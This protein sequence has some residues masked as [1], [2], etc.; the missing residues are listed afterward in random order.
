MVGND[1]LLRALLEGNWDAL[2]G[3]FFTIKREEV[4]V[5]PSNIPPDWQPFAG[6]DYGETNATEAWLAAIDYDDT[7]HMVSI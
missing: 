4:M 2:V 3:S 7:V 5:E 6:M 1:A